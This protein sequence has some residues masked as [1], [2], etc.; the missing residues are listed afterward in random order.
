M[1]TKLQTPHPYQYVGLSG[2]QASLKAQELAKVA[3]K[4]GQTVLLYKHLKYLI[5]IITT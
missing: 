3:A 2:E 4:T 5:P 1:L